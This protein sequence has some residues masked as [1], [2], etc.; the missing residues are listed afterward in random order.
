MPLVLSRQQGKEL[1]QNTYR[2]RNRRLNVCIFYILARLPNKHNHRRR[3]YILK[4]RAW[5]LPWWTEICHTKHENGRRSLALLGKHDQAH[6]EQHSNSPAS[7]EPMTPGRCRVLVSIP[8][9]LLLSQPP[10][11]RFCWWQI[12][13]KQAQPLI[14]RTN[15]LTQALYMGHSGSR[16]GYRCIVVTL[17]VLCLK[18]KSGYT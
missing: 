3:G 2:M 6:L 14:P 4:A 1:D 11:V 7:S 15:L 8:P 9:A 17:C 12:K 16:F 18:K 10:K 13:T 5:P